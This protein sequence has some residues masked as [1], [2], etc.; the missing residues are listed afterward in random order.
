MAFVR[1]LLLVLALLSSSFTAAAARETLVIGITQYP[2]TLHPG[3]DSMLA[4]SYVLGF[5]QR[6]FTVYDANW[7]LVCLLCTELPTLD[8]GGARREMTPEGG[9]GV[10]LTITIREDAFW[11]DG[12]PITSGDVEFA[13]RVGRNPLSGVL[14][15]EFYKRL[16]RLDVVDD[17]T[18]ILHFDRLTHDYNAINSFYPLPA[19][20]ETE[21]FSEPSAYRHRTLYATDPTNP[22]LYNGPYIIDQVVTGSHIRLRRNQSWKGSPPAFE[23]LIIRTIEN[24]AA[25]EANLLSGAID[26]IAGE[27]GLTLDQA[28]AFEKRHGEQFQLIYKPGLIYEHIDLNLDNPILED[29][30]VR[31]AL[32]HAIDREAI[33][34]Q[35]FGSRQ[36]VASGPVSPLDPMFANDI[37]QYPFDPD[38]AS[39]LLREAGWT[40]DET[41]MLQNRAGDRLQLELMTTAGD[42]TRELVQQVLQSQWQ[43]AGID[44]RIRNQPARVFF[45]ETVTKR[46]FTGLAMF[47]WISAPDSVPRTTLHSSEIPTA[48]NG[49]VGQNTP[50]FRNEEVDRLIDDMEVEMNEERR[51]QMWKRLQEIYAERL[52]AIPLYFRANA[53]VLPKWLSGI[54]PTGHQYPTTLW[55]EHWRVREN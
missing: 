40:L 35:L 19:H 33:S 18:V 9:E 28:L 30:R 32:I 27:L 14:P 23:T 5:A 31:R 10:A 25:I 38:Q 15:T 48:A 6:P 34:S 53:F 36:P 47:A 42:R 16:Y 37:P 51:R 17:K 29:V 26:M 7:Q 13:W 8:N 55:V 49:Y 20:I 52:P 45:G 41:G 21:A 44:I 54:E 39:E 12:T 3:I 4:K 11:G 43:Q 50:G 1:S 24:T 22:A 2:S 46:Q